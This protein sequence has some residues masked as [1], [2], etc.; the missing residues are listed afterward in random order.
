MQN[1]RKTSNLVWTHTEGMCDEGCLEIDTVDR[2]MDVWMDGLDGWMY[3]DGWSYFQ[4]HC[5]PPGVQMHHRQNRA[6][7]FKIYK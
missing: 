7:P 3:M 4:I 5:T 6:C 2:W 1:I